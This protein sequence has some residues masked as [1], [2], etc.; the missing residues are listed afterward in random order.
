MS[1]W[2]FV[3]ILVVVYALILTEKIPRVL[4]ALV[5][6][7]ATMIAGIALGMFSFEHPTPPGLVNPLEFIELETIMLIVGML[8]IVEVA[9]ESGLF[10][11]IAIQVIKRV[12]DS[13]AKLLTTMCTLIFLF[14]TI[15][16]N[17]VSTMIIGS[18]TM[19]ACDVLEYDPLPYVISE[20][21]V[22]DA[23]GMALVTS[24]IPSITIASHPSVDPPI[25]FGEFAITGLPLATILGLVLI[26]VLRRMNRKKLITPSESRVS[27]IRSQLDAFDAWSVVENI[28]FFYSSAAVL[29]GV[30][31]LFVIGRSF[32]ITI[33]FA[34]LLGAIAMLFFTRRVEE[35]IGKVRW[36]TIFFFIGLFITIGGVEAAGVLDAIARGLGA[37][38]GANLPLAIV[39]MGLI[40]GLLSGVVD[41]IPVALTFIPVAQQ[42]GVNVMGL[43]NAHPLHWSLLSCALLGGDLLPIGSPST[44]IAMDILKKSG[45]KLTTMEFLKYSGIILPI[46]L[47]IALTY[48]LVVFAL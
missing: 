27:V 31:I 28:Y 6:A 16:G 10:Q 32:G 36:D 25:G 15:I 20:V 47:G 41:N 9:R 24:S 17:I 1:M 33:G 38:V 5:G 35:S 44:I 12:G 48:V 11:F 46:S 39:L 4:A 2:V 43:P 37:V 8:I 18:L 30:I 14:T 13:P 23:A 22:A 40:G 19:I 29:T 34:A 3:G 7:V 21:F 45:I 26:F 42:L